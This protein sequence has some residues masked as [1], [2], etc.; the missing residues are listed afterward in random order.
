MLIAIV[1]DDKRDLA[2]ME[3]LCSHYALE[4]RVD[5]ETLPYGSVAALLEDPQRQNI[6]VL[7]LD[8]V[9][10]AGEG[11]MAGGLRAARQ[12]R[13]EGYTGVIIFTTGSTDYYPEG[14]EVGAAH[15]LVKPVDDDAFAQAMERARR[16]LGERGRSI[17]LPVN[18]LQVQLF[19][20]DILYAEVY[21]RHTLLHTV[22]D[23]LDLRMPLRKLQ[24]LLDSP[25]FL[26][27]FRSYLINMQWVAHMEEDHFV[28]E[29]GDSIPIRLRNRQEIRET[30]MSY[31]MAALRQ[32]K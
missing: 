30:Y 18:R 10:G 16:H 17:T 23:N 22:G 14:F 27:C 24:Q 20:K 1:E 6:D 7:L 26:L 5:M 8:I 4:Y 13:G 21:G 19:H 12:L 31:R 9:M 2:H 15:Y 32:G 29:N 11:A 28:M 3:R 25:Y